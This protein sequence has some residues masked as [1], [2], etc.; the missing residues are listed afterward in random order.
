[1]TLC[2]YQGEERH[3]HTCPTS[4]KNDRLRAS[5][6]CRRSAGMTRRRE[7]GAAAAA[8]LLVLVLVLVVAVVVVVASPGLVA[9]L[10]LA[11]QLPE[12][13]TR[14]AS[15]SR[16]V[17]RATPMPSPTPRAMATHAAAAAVAAW[18]L[19]RVVVVPCSSDICRGGGGG[20]G[21]LLAE[22]KKFALLATRIPYPFAAGAAPSATALEAA[23]R[24][25]R[26]G[27]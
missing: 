17:R 10:S 22:A 21:P 26:R 15:L 5:C 18:W 14:V 13:S 6:S 2:H 24:A 3:Q 19:S 9:A 12:P 8:S 4:P 11:P 25:R 20:G 27:P 7:V 23:C 1:V 16:S